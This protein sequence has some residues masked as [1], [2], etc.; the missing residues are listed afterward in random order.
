MNADPLGSHMQLALHRA[1][2]RGD[3][4]EVRRL[5]DSGTA[6]DEPDGRPDPATVARCVE[7]LTEVGENYLP[8]T[9]IGQT[10]LMV[11]VRKGKRDVAEL[12]L[13]RGAAPN[14]TDAVGRTPLV[15]AVEADQPELAESLL[16]R[17]ADANATD[18]AHRPI[19]TRAVVHGSHVM[20]ELLLA[21]GA[22]PSAADMPPE[23]RPLVRA[24]SLDANLAA[25]LIERC[26]DRAV[27]DEHVT[28]A[29]FNDPRVNMLRCLLDRGFD[30]NRPLAD[31][32][33]PLAAATFNRNRDR[34]G[35]LELLLERGADPARCEW[36][37]LF[38]LLDEGD[39]TGLR[40]LVAAGG[41]LDA[42]I[43]ADGSTYLMRLAR[44]DK[45]GTM[46]RLALELGAESSVRDR[47]GRSALDVARD[48]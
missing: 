17:G 16:R 1:A 20:I 43:V 41:R 30:P 18:L 47:R 42:P 38:P 45:S 2:G 36:S 44:W 48:H 28:E 35:V 3:A 7:M 24:A 34:D 32:R 29:A 13:E 40:G 19:L 46:T 12:L 8:K 10:A 25:W 22:D 23:R 21:H 4:G 39:G 33:M 5:L 14:A 26:G 37:I 15:F 31:G 27:I 6:V 9:G 11:A